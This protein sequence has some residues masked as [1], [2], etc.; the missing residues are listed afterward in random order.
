MTLRALLGAAATR[1]AAGSSGWPGWPW[2]ASRREIRLELPG[3]GDD[4]LRA[5]IRAELAEIAS[6]PGAERNAALGAGGWV[7]PHMPKPWGRGAG[8][9]EQLIIDEE[10]RT[11]GL[12]RS[13]PCDW[14]LGRARAHP[15]R[16]AGAAAAVPAGHAARR[17]PVVPAVQRARRRVRPGRADH[18]GRAGRRRLADHRAEDLDLAGAAGGVGDLHR[19]HRSGA[20]AARRDQLLPRR[21]ALAGRRGQAAARDRRRCVL[22]PG[23]PGR[24]LR[25]RRLPGRRGEQ[26]LAHRADDA[27][28]RAGLA[29]AVVDVRLRG[30]RAAGDGDG[31]RGRAAALR[32]ASWSRPAT[33]STCSACGRRSSSCP[34][35]SPAPPAACASCSACGTR[36]RSPSC[37]GRCRQAAARWPAAQRAAGDGRTASPTARTGPARS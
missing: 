28:E 18:Q 15:V 1:T 13:R 9:L 7:L 30:A 5:S 16:H 22:Q 24:G 17:L 36:S 23:V 27:G 37:A 19:A 14:R 4:E 34:G 12:A 6:L 31:G 25:A 32:S 26:G 20:A 3:G 33:P 35:P 10:L 2:P 29:V 8:A 21:H 11:A